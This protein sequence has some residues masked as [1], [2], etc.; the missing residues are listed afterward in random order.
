MFCPNCGKEIPDNSV[1]CPDCGMS[2]G[3]NGDKFSDSLVKNG[4][5]L[6]VLGY[7][8][9]ILF[10]LPLA[11]NGKKTPYGLK[12]ANAALV[13]L[14]VS[15]VCGLITGILK[16]TGLNV[17]IPTTIIS[18]IE[19]LMFALQIVGIVYACQGSKKDIP[20]VGS[21]HMLDK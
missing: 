5:A 20:I 1:F 2:T 10:F 13:F 15:V 8:F 16:N 3:S 11:V 7:I 18:I 21:L 6:A 4:K 17:W 9:P 12:H 14:I 19:T